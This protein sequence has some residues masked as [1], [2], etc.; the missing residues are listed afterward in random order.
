MKRQPTKLEQRQAEHLAEQ[1]LATHS[2]K[3]QQQ[4][5]RTD[6]LSYHLTLANNHSTDDGDS[7]DSDSDSD[8]DSSDS[9]SDN[10]ELVP[11]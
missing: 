3:Q 10:S 8:S 6:A 4:H 7:S 5:Q 9:S 2:A 11:L 1:P